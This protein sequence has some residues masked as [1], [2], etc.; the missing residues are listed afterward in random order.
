[1]THLKSWKKR[2]DLKKVELIYSD[3]TS[4]FVSNEDFNR[5]FGTII[6]CSKAEVERDFAVDAVEL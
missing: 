2:K 3:G 5:A 1:M 6:R 4:L